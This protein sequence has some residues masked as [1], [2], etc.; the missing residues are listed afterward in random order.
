MSSYLILPQYEDV[1]H[2]WQKQSITNAAELE[3]V[4]NG[5]IIAFAYHS[6]KIENAAITYNDTREIFEHDR[7]SAYTGSLRTLF[8]IRNAK[9][10]SDFILHA[11]E[12]ERPL[13][14]PFLQDLQYQLTKNTYDARRYSIGERPGTFKQNDYVTGKEEVGAPPEDVRAELEELLAD[15]HAAAL[16]T[17]PHVLTGAAFFHAKFENIHPFAD[18]NGRTGRLAMNY[19]LLQHQFPPLVFHEEDRNAYYDALAAWD[20]KQELAPLKDFIQRQTIKTWQKGAPSEDAQSKSL[21]DFLS[22]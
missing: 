1:V 7:V 16:K 22:E 18:G 10:A 20:K 3:A 21:R 15:I 4:L 17:V 5:Y 6:G 2:A 14:I 11:F 19:L 9:D 12:Q 13:D 8:E